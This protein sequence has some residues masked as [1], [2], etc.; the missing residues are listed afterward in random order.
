MADAKLI[1]TLSSLLGSLP[2]VKEKQL[3]N[4]TSFFTGKN[5]FVF[6]SRTS[7]MFCTGASRMRAATRSICDS[8]NAKLGQAGAGLIVIVQDS[9]IAILTSSVIK[10]NRTCG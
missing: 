1:A 10:R 3:P 7:T 5:I 2:G 9:T 6:T 4:H 8:I